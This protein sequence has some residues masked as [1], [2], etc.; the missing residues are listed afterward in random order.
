MKKIVIHR[1]GGYDQLRL[2]THSDPL[3]GPGQVLLRTCGIGV[4]YADCIVRMGLYRS[5]R[6]L[7]G[8]P[9]TPGFEVSGVV[10]S[11]GDGVT[12]LQVGDRVLAVTRF[13]GYA[14]RVVVPRRQ[15]FGLPKGFDL[16]QAAGF[17][18]VHLTAYFAVMELARPRAGAHVLVHSAAG[19]VGGAIVRL[20]RHRGC[21]VIGVVGGTHKITAALEQG[22]HAVIDASRGDLWRQAEAYAPA[23]YDAIFDAN[24][25]ATLRQSY[26]HLAATGRL[27]V[28]GFA[29]MLPRD[30]RRLAWWRL[31]WDWLLTP[32][33]DPLDLTARNRSVM[34]FNLSYLFD[35]Q[36][37]LADGMRQLLAWAEQGILRPPP[38]MTFPLRDAARAHRALESGTTVG[39]IVL[40]PPSEPIDD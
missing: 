27:V 22:A 36:V 4:N 31:L 39:K 23:G 24:G 10:V 7:V 19:G 2:E 5:A 17:P 26:R 20:A 21:H 30:G 18:A 38:T 12:D 6:E 35:R 34:G 15:V 9:I 3:P 11:L 40:V 32:R 16:V 29:S 37:L 28:Y 8:W 14:S 33:F 1:R 25:V 13:G